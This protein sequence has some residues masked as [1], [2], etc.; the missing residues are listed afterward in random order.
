MTTPQAPKKELSLEEIQKMHKEVMEAEVPQLN[1]LLLEDNTI[2]EKRDQLSQLYL[3]IFLQFS[4]LK[5]QMAYCENDSK[6]DEVAVLQNYNTFNTNKY[7]M[8][9]AEMQLEIINDILANKE[10][11]Q[12]TLKVASE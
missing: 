9:Y 3:D 2:Y 5:N 11:L 8:K 4:A 12:D 10:K 1:L 7:N 6:K